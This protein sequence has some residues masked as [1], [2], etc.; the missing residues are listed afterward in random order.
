[1]R[2]YFTEVAQACEAVGMLVLKAVLS[3]GRV[4][5]A[6]TVGRRHLWLDALGYDN[7]AVQLFSTCSTAGN[8]GL[9]GC[10][11]DVLAKFKAE[12]TEREVV[13]KALA[14][15]VKKQPAAPPAGAGRGRGSY[16]AANSAKL[17]T[18]WTAGHS[19]PP[20]PV[21]VL[22]PH[23]FRGCLTFREET[24]DFLCRWALTPFC[25]IMVPMPLGFQ[26]LP[27]KVLNMLIVS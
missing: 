15:S 12:Q 1:M 16:A 8:Q 7:T 22:L 23:E 25:C 10:T 18:F 14:S 5:A 13:V 27:M 20:S 19:S 26:A 24:M 9:C 21:T 4:C 11:A 2:E 3:V 17:Q 6:A